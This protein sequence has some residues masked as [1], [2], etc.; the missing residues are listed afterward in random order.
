M[1]ETN[2]HS[3]LVV[4]REMTTSMVL[5]DHLM[6]GVRRSTID[7]ASLYIHAGIDRQRLKDLNYRIPVTVAVKLLYQ[8]ALLLKDESLGLLPRPIPIGYFHHSVLSVIQQQNLG[9]ALSRYVEFSNVFFNGLELALNQSG[10]FVQLIMRRDGKQPIQDN[11]AIEST[12]ATIQRLISWLCNETVF[13]EQVTLDYPPPRYHREFRYLFYGAPV[14]FNDSVCSIKFDASYMKLPVVQNESSAENYVRGSPMNVYVPQDVSGETSR[15][16][17]NKLKVAT[18]NHHFSAEL[19]QIARELNLSTQTLRR[20]LA[21]E[22]TRFN[23]IKSQVRRDI[24]I[25][26]L[27][28]IQSSI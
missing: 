25:N 6:S 8:S 13:L 7:I 14:K 24:A 16:I 11:M 10:R 28:D 4:S 26:A 27:G 9:K 22:G 17:R 18:S 19:Q 2:N 5:F 20:R 3:P 1:T 12:I 23:T 21:K 15:L